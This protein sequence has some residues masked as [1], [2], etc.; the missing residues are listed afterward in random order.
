MKRNSSVTRFWCQTYR[1]W[2]RVTKNRMTRGEIGWVHWYLREPVENDDDSREGKLIESFGSFPAT[3]CRSILPGTVQKVRGVPGS[4]KSPPPMTRLNL[5]WG[6]P[7]AIRRLVGCGPRAWR[8][9]AGNPL[10][11]CIAWPVCTAR[12]L[13]NKLKK[14]WSSMNEGPSNSPKLAPWG[15]FRQFANWTITILK[16]E[17]FIIEP[18]GQKV[19]PKGALGCRGPVVPK[20]PTVK[21]HSDWR[22]LGR[23]AYDDLWWPFYQPLSTIIQHY[24]P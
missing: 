23:R 7:I 18:S 8:D 1:V 17:E 14:I 24:S 22:R 21:W 12:V 3:C 10:N 11:F 13:R 5:L 19:W 16:N 4:L 15:S 6:N 2:R 20:A 9:A